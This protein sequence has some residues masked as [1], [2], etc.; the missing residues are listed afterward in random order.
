MK[1]LIVF[2]ALNFALVAAHELHLSGRQILSQRSQL[3]SYVST[4]AI[5]SKLGQVNKTDSD[6]LNKEIMFDTGRDG[7]PLELG[8]GDADLVCLSNT[9]FAG[10]FTL[11]T[12]S[13]ACAIVVACQMLSYYERAMKRQK[14]SGEGASSNSDVEMASRDKKKRD[15]DGNEEDDIVRDATG[16]SK[17]N[18]GKAKKN[19]SK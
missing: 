19:K 3:Y 16:L 15:D 11:F 4:K 12:F 13:S 18:V 6:S 5:E 14:V 17:T 2:A 1:N 8:Y 10:L 7:D 9:L